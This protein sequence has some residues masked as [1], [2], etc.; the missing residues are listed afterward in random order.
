[1]QIVLASASPRR[2]ELLKKVVDQ[3]IVHPPEVDEKAIKEA[4]PVKLAIQ[5]AVM[6]AKAAAEKY[7]FSLVVAADTVVSLGNQTLGKPSSQAEARLMLKKLSG[8]KHKVITGLALYLKAEDKLLTDYELTYVTFRQLTDE[9]IDD[10]LD[11][12]DF[13]DKAGGYAVQKVKDA[14]VEKIEGNYENVVGFPVRKFK[15]LLDRFLVPELVV[16]VVDVALPHPWAV[17]RYQNQVIF[18]NSGLPGDKLR[19]RTSGSGKNFFQAEMVRIEQPSPDRVSPFCP[20][21]GVCGGCIFQDLA[22]SRQLIL[23]QEHIYQSF[24]KIAG[25]DLG[26]SQVILMFPSPTI[27]QYRNKMEFAFGE[28][29]GQLILGLRQRSSVT[30]KNSGRVI[31]LTECPIF[32]PVAKTIFPIFLDFGRKRKD[33][34]YHPRARKGFLRHLVLRQGKKT[35]ELMVILVTTAADIPDFTTLVEAVTS[36]CLETKSFYWVVNNQVSDVVAFEQKN[37]LWGNTYIEEKMA[38]FSFRLH[39]QSFFQPNTEAALSLYQKLTELASQSGCRKA[40]GL[41]CG[42]GCLEIFLS[43]AVNEVIGV[44]IN[45]VNIATAEENCRINQVT[46]CSF[47]QGMVEKTLLGFS[48]GEFD[49]LVLDPPRAGLTP[50]ALKLTISLAIPHLAYVSCNPATLAR[51][52]KPLVASGYQIQQVCGFDFFPHTGHIETLVWLKR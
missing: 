38:N 6:K 28:E 1:M 33:R 29:G 9:Q 34:A 23:K 27:F 51:D 24:R 44:D 50:K 36:V 7:P 19:V 37:Q 21:F 20:H 52:I 18:V 25:L 4:D 14:F 41:Y 16:E 26:T 2:K 31:P 3:F 30:G 39:P 17:A 13:E 12:G 49:L 32:S 11:T 8:S 35:G 45:P 47:L 10:Y 46:N 48:A 40:L 42:S 43:T 22:Y 15:K 5:L